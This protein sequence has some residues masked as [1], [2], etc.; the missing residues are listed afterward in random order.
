MCEG[1]FEKSITRYEIGDTRDV[2]I[3]IIENRISNPFQIL[4]ETEFLFVVILLMVYEIGFLSLGK[5]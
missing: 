3:I 4:D 5:E 1:K 2:A